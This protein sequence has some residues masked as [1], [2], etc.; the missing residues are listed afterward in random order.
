MVE[1]IAAF[2]DGP[3]LYYSVRSLG[4]DLDFSRLFKFVEQQGRLVRTFYYTEDVPSARSLL[5]WLAY[6]GV[7]VRTTPGK[8]TNA[9]EGSLKS[10]HS[11]GIGL[12]VDAFEMSSRVDRVLLFSRDGDFRALLAAIQRRGVRATVVSALRSNQI[13]DELRRQADEYIDLD[14]IRRAIERADN[15]HRA[16]RASGPQLS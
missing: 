2:I 1:K 6:H 5:D 8:G 4:F 16:E 14:S 12:A 3:N 7:T 9:R 15:R 13:S 11:W 10:K